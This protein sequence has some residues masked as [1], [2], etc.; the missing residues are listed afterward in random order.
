MLMFSFYLRFCMCWNMEWAV[1]CCMGLV[2]FNF[3]LSISWK[4]LK[5]KIQFSCQ[6]KIASLRGPYWAHVQ[7]KPKKCHL[8]HGLCWTIF[9]F[10]ANQ[11]ITKGLPCH[12]LVITTS[13]E[14]I[15]CDVFC[16]TWH[17]HSQP[18][19]NICDVSWVY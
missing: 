7:N 15:F 1:M 13:A 9:C 10:V 16:P 12:L 6:K 19:H 8:V 17:L 14:D 18:W 5:F 11:I 4:K 3:G 2:Q